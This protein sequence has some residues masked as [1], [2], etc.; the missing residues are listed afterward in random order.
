M[1]IQ[2]LN[3]FTPARALNPSGQPQETAQPAPDQVDFSGSRP[4]H[5]N[6]KKLAKTAAG[7]VGATGVA[8]A[9]YQLATSPDLATG[10]VRAAF[11]LAGGALGVVGV[12]LVSG[13]GHHW[14]DNY[15]LPRPQ[16]L[17]HTKW[18]TDLKQ[19][20]YCLVGLSNKAL[21]KI[22]FWP[23]WEKLIHTTTGKTPVSWQVP[24]YKSFCQGEIDKATLETELAK[25]G[26]K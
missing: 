24:A 2:N 3:T 15:G 14:G 13:V 9:A 11:C 18:H 5:R 21:D 1:Q 8:A 23:R 16:S 10:A 6:V 19:T 17:D 4:A 20:D 7:V 22:G 12:D 26:L 25:A